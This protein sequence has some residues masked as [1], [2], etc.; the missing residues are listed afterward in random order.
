MFFELVF[1]RFLGSKSSR[2]LW[3][4]YELSQHDDDDD[5]DDDE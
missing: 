4:G 3:A 5:D 1:G 2:T